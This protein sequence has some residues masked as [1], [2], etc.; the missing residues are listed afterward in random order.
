[1]IRALFLAAWPGCGER[2]PAAVRVPSGPGPTTRAPLCQP[3]R[4][5]APGHPTVA[6]ARRRC[7]RGGS[8]SQEE[9]PGPVIRS[10]REEHE[11]RDPARVGALVDAIAEDRQQMQRLRNRHVLSMAHF[12]APLLR[13]ILRLAG[14][15]EKCKARDEHPLKGKILSN[16]F[17]DNSRSH[18]RLSFNSAWLRMGGSLLNFEKAI[19]QV[20]LHRHAPDELVQLC[21]SYGDA[22]VLR[23]NDGQELTEMVDMF[24]IPLIN[25]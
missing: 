8:M 25:A 19:D 4:P 11:V 20:T 10:A 23:T 24:E 22:A 5:P 15:I 16:L 14:V 3:R 21:N 12:D 6:D 7:E 9:L 18:T 17:W 2:R 13:Q 1:M